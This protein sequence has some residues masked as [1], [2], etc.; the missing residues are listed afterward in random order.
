MTTFSTSVLRTPLIEDESI[1]QRVVCVAG[2]VYGVIAALVFG[3]TFWGPNAL[4][5]DDASAPVGWQMLALGLIACV[6]I[7]LLIGWL[8][9]RSRWSAIS[10][11]LWI[12]AGALFAWI[13]GRLP[14]DGLSLLARFNDPYPSDQMMYPFTVPAAGFTGISMVVGA[15]AGLFVGMLSLVATDRAWEASTDRHRLSVKSIL[16]LLISAPP[17]IAFGLL[18]DFQINAP[19][20]DSALEV[21]RVIRIATEPATDLAQARLT[22]M[23][24]FRAQLV[25]GHTLLWNS[26]SPELIRFIIDAQFD[27]GLLLRCPFSF[28]SVSLC[29]NVGRDIHDWMTQLMTTGHTTCASC[30]VQVDRETRRW[31]TQ[32]L[33]S[34]GTLREVKLLKHLGGWLYQRA[35]FDSERSIDCRFSGDRPIKVDLCVEAR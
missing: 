5:L 32:V 33:P 28:G 34:M 17:L 24:S 10:I 30:S 22:F 21:N 7:G 2:T 25:P 31:L 1:H 13:G 12:I 18:A 19:L 8:A 20:R 26:N 3:L 14:Y 29:S 6:P 27:S 4:M 11:V 15:G 9:A 16:L 23:Q 35:T